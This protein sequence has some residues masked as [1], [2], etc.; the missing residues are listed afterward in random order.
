MGVDVKRVVDGVD[1][2]LLIVPLAEGESASI[3]AYARH[4][5]VAAQCD[6]RQSQVL[7]GKNRNGRIKPQVPKP[8]R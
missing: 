2:S 4:I 7:Q 6:L 3:H 5:R 1:G 8:N